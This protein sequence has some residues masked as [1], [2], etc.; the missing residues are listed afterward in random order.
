MREAAVESVASVRYVSLSVARAA[1]PEAKAPA[2]APAVREA[3][4]HPGEVFERGIFLDLVSPSVMKALPCSAVTLALTILRSS[5]SHAA[6][7]PTWSVSHRFS[8][9]FLFVL[10]ND[11]DNDNDNDQ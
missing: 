3:S 1:S 2:T 7:S 11:S 4:E 8:F 5:P 6:K 10:F 9:L